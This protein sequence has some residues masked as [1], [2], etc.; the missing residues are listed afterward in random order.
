[1]KLG[2]A[3]H[4]TNLPYFQLAFASCQSKGASQKGSDS[5]IIRRR[6]TLKY[7]A[8]ICWLYCWDK[9]HIPQWSWKIELN[10]ELPY[11]I[12]M[13]GMCNHNSSL[14]YYLNVKLQYNNNDNVLK[15]FLQGW[16][17]PCWWKCQ[18]WYLCHQKSEIVKILHKLCK[19]CGSSVDISGQFG[20]FTRL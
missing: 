13:M 4:T 5:V 17:L 8:G 3:V 14:I 20:F 19:I 15:V 18:L 11:G 1:M 7:V 12:L 9:S 10:A 16:L 6:L 2:A